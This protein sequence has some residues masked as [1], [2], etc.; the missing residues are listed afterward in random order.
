MMG[1]DNLNSTYEYLE[2]VSVSSVSAFDCYVP[3]RILFL[4]GKPFCR[5]MA[6]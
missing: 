3:N 1:F 4:Q 2:A 5:K 6:K